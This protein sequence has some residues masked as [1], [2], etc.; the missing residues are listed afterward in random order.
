MIYI[1]KFYKTLNGT[2]AELP[3]RSVSDAIR[4]LRYRCFQTENVAD[5]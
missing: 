5:L 2:Y 1:T 4:E 3:I